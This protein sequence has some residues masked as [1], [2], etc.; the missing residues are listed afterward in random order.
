MTVNCIIVGILMVISFPWEVD[1][2]WFWFPPERGNFY[3]LGGNRLGEDI[4]PI[5]PVLYLHGPFSLGRDRPSS[6]ISRMK[7]QPH[8]GS[9]L[10]SLEG[11]FSLPTPVGSLD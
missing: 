10:E 9:F 8:G 1:P 7:T 2:T 4:W 11:R 6:S 3:C 5:T